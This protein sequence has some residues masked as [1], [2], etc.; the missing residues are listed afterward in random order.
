[1][2]K[3]VVR[4][5]SHKGKIFY[6]EPATVTFN[7]KIVANPEWVGSDCITILIDDSF[8][9]MRIIPKKHIVGKI[10]KP[11]PEKRYR[12]TGSKGDIYRVTHNHGLW[13]CQCKGFEFHGDCRHIRIVKEKF[14][15]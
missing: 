8:M 10:T 9:P 4:N 13:T 2:T 15:R 7:G 6:Y 3:V 11:S 5:P 1:M 12:V 14:M